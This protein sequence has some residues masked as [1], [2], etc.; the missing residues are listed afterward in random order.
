MSSIS[1]YDLQQKALKN[2]NN[3]RA[4]VMFII[5]INHCIAVYALNNSGGGWLPVS[6]ILESPKVFEWLGI[7]FSSFMNYAFVIVSGYVY[8]A[9]RFENGKY[10][11]FLPFI[12]NKVKRLIIPAIFVSVIWIIPICIFAL[13]F[14]IKEIVINFA[15]GVFPRQLWFV[16]MLF[17]VFMIFAPLAKFADKNFI[18][19]VFFVGGCY[20]IGKFGGRLTNDVNYYRFLDGFQYVIYFWIGFCLRKYGISKLLKIPSVC[21]LAVNICMIIFKEYIM[22]V[23]MP[24][25]LDVATNLVIPPLVQISGGMMAFMVLQKLLLKFNPQGKII[26]LFSKFSFPMFMIHEQFIYLAV[27]WYEGKINPYVFSLVTFVWVIII[28]FTVSYLLGKNKITRFLIGI[29]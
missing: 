20:L 6:P 7:W 19:G 22:N 4:I 9:M 25:L 5:I 16:F 23:E 11:K 13:D 27:I 28:S 10:E 18:L 2:C 24:H 21:W 3:I 12:W 17:W 26:S 1:K 8:Y 29:K 15:L 14:S